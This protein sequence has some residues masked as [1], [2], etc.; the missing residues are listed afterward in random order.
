MAY[1]C[2]RATFNN[3][4]ISPIRLANAA[5]LALDSL[6][7]RAVFH[8]SARERVALTGAP[9]AGIALRQP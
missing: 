7:P 9:L 4:T 3:M 5:L 8:L 6:C 1:V 2:T